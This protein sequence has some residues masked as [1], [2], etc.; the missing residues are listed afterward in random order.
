[1]DRIKNSKLTHKVALLF[2]ASI[3]ASLIVFGLLYIISN[4]LLREVIESTEYRLAESEK[5]VTAFQEYVTDNNLSAEDID[6][7]RAWSNSNDIVYFTISRERMLI[8]DNA[9]S[10]NVPIDN[11]LS[12]QLNY[13]WMYFTPVTFADGEADVFIY[14]NT[15]KRFYLIANITI[16]VISIITGFVIFLIGI[17][18]EVSYV[19]KLSS[20]VDSMGNGLDTVAISIS[21][22]DEITN[23]AKAIEHMRVKLIEKEKKEQEMKAAQD[24]LVLGMA[25]DLRTPLTSLVAFIEIS[26]R[27]NDLKSAEVY[28]DKALVKA[29]QIKNMSDQLFDFFLINSEEKMEIE[30]VSTESAFSD[31]LSELVN[32]LSVQ[33]FIVNADNVTWDD[34]EVSVCFDYI[35]RIMNNI[36]SNITKYADKD[37]ALNLYTQ[38]QDK[39]FSIIFE[40]TI[41]K[42]ANDNSSNGIGEQ[43]IKTMMEKMNGEH[44]SGSMDNLYR[45]I[46]SFPTLEE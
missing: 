19:L 46:L 12:N 16:I 34:K 14:K 11:T 6:K 35:G 10:G 37:R 23:L 45:T 38:L 1:M 31:Y 43:N 44:T 39:T 29:N 26:K 42:H 20:E 8:Y 13:T 4:T 9:Y 3:T 32:C 25:H 17:R 15:E 5:L 22:N 24:K 7:I 36:Q 21:G 27:Q 30:T 18:K 40:N 33:G 28:S 41:S 2:A